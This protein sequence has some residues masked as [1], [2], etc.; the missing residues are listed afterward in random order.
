MLQSSL[1]P[2]AIASACAVGS[3]DQAIGLVIGAGVLVV[4]LPAGKAHTFVRRLRNA[5]LFTAVLLVAYAAVAV[6]PQPARWW[7]HARFVVSDHAPTTIPLSARGEVEIL[8]VTVRQLFTVFGIP[9]L[10]LSLA[11]AVFL[12][13]NRR[14]KELWL[15]CVPL[16]TYYCVIIAK[17]RVMYPRF[18]LPF[19]VPVIVL[20]MHGTAVLGDRL[21][22]SR[23]AA[24]AWRSALGALVVFRFAVSYAPVT[25]AQV[26]DLKRNVA[27]DLPGLLPPGSPLLL[28]R[29]QSYNFPNAHTYESYELM[30]VHEDPIQPPS[31]HAAS[32]FRPLDENVQHFLLGSGNAG[33]PWNAVGNYPPLP[34]QLVHEWRYPAWVKDRILE[35]CIFEFS[36]YQR[37][38]PLPL[39]RAVPGSTSP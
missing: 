10:L 31:R 21:F 19:F 3:K 16:L 4:C 11:G 37:T 2:A 20:V 18:T 5:V 7:F 9:V 8:I 13:A 6:L 25:Y 29:M 39:D 1:L 30:R 26:F 15:L 24:L 38:G 27:T 14:A 22:S 12:I 23:P 33:L 32:L 35:P 34:G 17:T 28:S 36:L